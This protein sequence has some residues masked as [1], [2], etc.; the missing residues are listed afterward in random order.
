MQKNIVIVG[1]PKSGTT[2]LSRLVADLVSCPLKGDWG[3]ENIDAPFM[4]GL[5][6]D[7]IYQV[8]KSHH[9]FYDIE[10]ASS[11]KI[12]KI[13]YIVRDPRDVVISGIYYFNFLPRFLIKKKII[14][15]NFYKKGYYK[16]TS[17]K[18]KKRQMIDAVLNGNSKINTWLANSWNK[19]LS[20]Y[21]QKNILIVT[22]EDLLDQSENQCNRILDYLELKRNDEQIKKSINRQSFNTRIVI[23]KNKTDKHQSKLL[24]KGAYGNWKKELT[25]KEINLFKTGL[26]NSTTLYRF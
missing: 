25:E 11:N 6:R 10:E 20:D 13:I 26:K 23:D 9:T 16:I 1:Y 19:H 15:N 7:S 22:Y 14:I 2:W 8:F 18:E 12:D 4:E 21:Q 3:F 17:K 24:R 5:E